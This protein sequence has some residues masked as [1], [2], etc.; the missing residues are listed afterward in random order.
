[1]KLKRRSDFL[2]G[3]FTL[4]TVAL[5]S[6]ALPTVLLQNAEGGF[7]F[8]WR[9]WP[10]LILAAA[11]LLAGS[12]LVLGAGRQ[13]ARTGVHLLGVRPGP[14]LLVDGWYRWVRHPQHVGTLALAAAPAVALSPKLLWVTAV[15]A[16]AWLVAGLEPLEER[17]LLE[18]FGDEFREYRRTVGRW[19][20][21]LTR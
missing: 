1:M 9:P 19:F 6:G 20:P 10:F 13:L 5:W 11:L 3:G 16:V 18:V 17:R 4:F 8:P 15:L 21:R 14:V 2:A 12:A 7:S